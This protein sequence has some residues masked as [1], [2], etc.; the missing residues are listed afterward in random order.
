L[1]WDVAITLSAD[2]DGGSSEKQLTA[3]LNGVAP[4]PTIRIREVILSYY[5]KDCETPVRMIERHD[6]GGTGVRVLP[7]KWFDE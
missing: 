1:D 4:N 3:F 7:G 2:D 5:L 6:A